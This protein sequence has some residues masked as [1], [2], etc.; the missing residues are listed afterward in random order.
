MTVTVFDNGSDNE[1]YLPD[2]LIGSQDA[3]II[4]YGS[5]NKVYIGENCLLMGAVIKLFSNCTFHAGASCRLAKMEVFAVNEGHVEIG[6]RSG[7]TWETEIQL[8]EPGRITIGSECLFGSGT[9]L[10]NSDM[11]SII[12]IETERRINPAEDIA[13]A[14][15]VWI[16]AGVKILKGSVVGNDSIIGL[17][18]IVTGTIPANSVAVGSPARVVR[19]GV[20][21]LHGL[22]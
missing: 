19:G 6:S 17:G 22:I 21:W 13:V 18:S 8:H 11:H 4:F 14:D 7:F 1:I 12:D 5:G 16:A 15:R 9:S 3:N 20:R 2:D 10:T